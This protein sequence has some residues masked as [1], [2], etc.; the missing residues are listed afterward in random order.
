MS[1]DVNLGI[2]SVLGV[3]RS[4][5]RLEG[6]RPVMQTTKTL[7]GESFPDT[8]MI[9]QTRV[10]VIDQPDVYDIRYENTSTPQTVSLTNFGNA[11]LTVDLPILASS[12]GVDPIFTFNPVDEL[13]G[14]ISIA[15]GTTSTFQLAYYGRELG[16]WSNALLLVSDTDIGNYKVITT[17]NVSNVYDFTIVP[18]SYI[19]TITVYARSISTDFNIVPYQGITETLTASL[20]GS[21]GYNIV[22]YNT[23]TVTVQFDPNLVG[24]VANTYST[25]LTVIGNSI[26][27]SA[28]ITTDIS[29]NVGNYS[30]YGSWIS[31]VS[32][33]N[34]VIGVSYDKIDGR[35]TITIGVG[36]GGS[37]IPEYASGGSIYANTD[38]LSISGS[39]VE[40]TYPYWACVF[41]IPVNANGDTTPKTYLSGALDENGQSAYLDKIVDGNNFYDYFGDYASQGSMFIVHDDGNGNIRIEMNRLRELSDDDRFNTTLQNLSRAFYYYSGVDLISSGVTSFT[42]DSSAVE[43]DV[44]YNE[45]LL[46][47]VSIYNGIYSTSTSVTISEGPGNKALLTFGDIVPAYSEITW[48]VYSRYPENNIGNLELLP[49]TPGG[50]YTVDGTLTR[51]FLGFLRSGEVVTSIVDQPVAD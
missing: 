14:E 20:S 13:A 5:K 12:D 30:N 36:I 4:T 15:P 33:Y 28:T 47:T 45:S 46:A 32:Y 18:T 9:L 41:R 6:P 2:K 40:P 37:G 23:T 24:N 31:P 19:S 17:Q 16:T 21:A 48:K 7:N 43:T 34:S 8:G 51:M 38:S 10:L 35:N 22:S 11:T 3:K 50:E 1:L 44:T 29:S 26:T 25:T 27:R 39:E 42:V 49:F